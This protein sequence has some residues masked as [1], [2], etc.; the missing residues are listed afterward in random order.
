MRHT[1]LGI[2]IALLLIAMLPSTAFSKSIFQS[3][4]LFP[5]GEPGNL[6]TPGAATLTRT[7]KRLSMTASVTGLEPG[8]VYTVW[9]V[10]FNRPEA[11]ENP[12]GD[13]AACSDLDF[14]IAKVGA[15]IIWA[16]GAIADDSGTARF[17]GELSKGRAPEGIFV[18]PVGIGRLVRPKRAEVHLLFV[19]HP[20]ATDLLGEV[21]VALTTPSGGCGGPCPHPAATIFNAP[22]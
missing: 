2:A 3:S 8:H 9:W 19:E 18:S 14:P 6:V 1:T 16:A 20:A 15:A 11:C 5:F 7:S 4:H 13:F 21:D 17:T 12:I 22:E 10:L